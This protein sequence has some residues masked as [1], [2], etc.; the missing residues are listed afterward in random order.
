MW[1]WP[2]TP[3]YPLS[4]Q[5]GHSF[6]IQFL[7]FGPNEMWI[8]FGHPPKPQSSEILGQP[9]G[10]SWSLGQLQRKF[11]FLRAV[12][13]GCTED[14]PGCKVMREIGWRFPS[15][16][17]FASP[18]NFPCDSILLEHIPTDIVVCPTC[19]GSLRVPAAHKT[20]CLTLG[21]TCRC[22]CYFTTL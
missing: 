12:R 2:S 15:V 16:C 14:K 3:S 19:Y 7:R 10:E 9:R 17:M 13:Q 22:L 18:C 11:D 6:F 5:K 21:W 20:V 8:Y 4:R 1:K